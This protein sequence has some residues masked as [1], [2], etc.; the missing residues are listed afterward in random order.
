MQGKLRF[1]MV[2]LSLW[3]TDIH[4]KQVSSSITDDFSKSTDLRLKLFSPNFK[5][6]HVN[7]L[8]IV[9]T[10]FLAAESIYLQSSLCSKKK[11]LG[12]IDSR[13][14]NMNGL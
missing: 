14:K 10:V 4:L 13:R 2:I 1:M 3:L 5:N 8:N 12:L 11:F 7:H 6:I 9:L